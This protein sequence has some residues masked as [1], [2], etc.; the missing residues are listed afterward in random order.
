MLLHYSHVQYQ[1]WKTATPTDSNCY[2]QLHTQTLTEAH[3]NALRAHN[4]AHK[5]T[6]TLD[7]RK[8]SDQVKQMKSLWPEWEAE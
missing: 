1:K 5:Y 6:F 8:W 4:Q 3:K 2:R 7:S